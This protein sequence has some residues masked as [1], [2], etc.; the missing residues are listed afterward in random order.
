MTAPVDQE[1][2]RRLLG[3]PELAWLVT[4]ARRRMARGKPLTGTVSRPAPSEGERVAAERLLGRAPRRGRSL[5]VSLEALDAVLRRSEISPD[6]LEP[7]VVALTGPVEVRTE[8]ARRAERAWEEAFAPLDALCATRPDLADWH[9]ELHAGGLVRRLAGTPEA[10]APLL[11]DLAAVLAGLPHPG[12]ER[13]VYAARVCGDAH[14][15]DEG[16]PLATLAFSAARALHPPPPGEGAA[17]RREVWASVGLLRDALSSTVL[18]LGLPGDAH[19]ATGRALAVLR[20]AGQPAVLTLRQLAHAPPAEWI[21]TVHV[22][23]NPAVVSAAADRLGSD[24]PPLVCTQGQPGTAA[25]ALLRALAVAG[26][27][28][29]YHGDFDWGGIRIANALRRQV[30]WTPWR[31]RAADYRTAVGA[32]VPRSRSRELTG[33]PVEADW[34]PALASALAALGVPVEEEQVLD[35]LLADLA[36]GA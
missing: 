6:G 8:A 10:A 19:S 16:R 11:A 12:T 1:R 21:G 23:E 15:L 20:E 25:L 26:A 34:D 9:R 24:C 29:R 36:A 31:Y 33:S 32:V 13:S 18:A 35:A 28:L 14:A 5:T 3:P 17:W 7:A 27:A 2:L 4:S 30:A 22:C